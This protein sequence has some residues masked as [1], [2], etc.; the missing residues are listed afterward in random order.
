MLFG[1]SGLPPPSPIFALAAAALIELEILHPGFI[2]STRARLE[3]QS[4]V[5]AAVRLRG[6]ASEPAVREAIEGALKWTAILTAI[7]EIEAPPKRK[8]SW[9]WT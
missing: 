8:R 9:G 3:R 2:E 5:I 1:E 6:P 4:N 7:G